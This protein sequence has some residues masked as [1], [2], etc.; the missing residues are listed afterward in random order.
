MAI[1]RLLAAVLLVVFLTGCVTTARYTSYTG[2]KFPAKKRHYFITVYWDDQLPSTL[3]RYTVIGKVEIAGH[4]SDGV[5]FDMLM[6]QAKT[7]A[8]KR[9]ADAIIH[10]ATEQARYKGTYVV[11]GHTT[12]HPVFFGPYERVYVGRY[13]PTRY[14]PYSDSILRFRGELIVFNAPN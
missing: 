13:H 7:M 2:E 6:D 1:K 3:Q 14:I 5:S 11:P 9:G 8:R 4:V 10:A 12:Y